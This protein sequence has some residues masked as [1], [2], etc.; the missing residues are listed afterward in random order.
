MMHAPIVYL[1]IRVKPI[2]P[3]ALLVVALWCT[4]RAGLRAKASV[5]PAAYLCF[6]VWVDFEDNPIV[7]HEPAKQEA[8]C[9]Q[10]LRVHLPGFGPVR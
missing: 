1:F 9:Q 7:F 10:L 8:S 5:A 4:N 2:N 3:F 6:G